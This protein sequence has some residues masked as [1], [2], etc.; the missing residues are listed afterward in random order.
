MIFGVLLVGFGVGG[1]RRRTGVCVSLWLRRFV[2]E[3]LGRIHRMPPHHHSAAM[4]GTA[5]D[6]PF[7]V[8]GVARGAGPEELRAAFRARARDAHPVRPVTNPTAPNTRTAYG[9]GEGTRR[10]GQL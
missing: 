3:S 9:N 8:L 7:A 4:A 1:K 2:K 6:D 10:R 5:D